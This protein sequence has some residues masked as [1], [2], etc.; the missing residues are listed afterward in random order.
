MSLAQS[1]HSETIAF[2]PFP[3]LEKN[4]VFLGSSFYSE[5]C[6]GRL[7]LA[8][9]QNKIYPCLMVSF[10]YFSKIQIFSWSWETGEAER[11]SFVVFQE[12]AAFLLIK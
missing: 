8:Q 9:R 12:D 2:L 4:R 6:K 7:A 3:V 5:L 11:M 1:E 10:S